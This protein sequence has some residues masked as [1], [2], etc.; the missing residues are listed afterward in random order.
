[1]RKSWVL[2][3]LLCIWAV[4]AAATTLVPMDL[5]DLT[6]ESSSVVYGKIVASRTEWDS[7]HTWIFTVYTVQP[8]EYLKGNL[9]TAFELS[10]LGGELDGLSMSVPAVPSFTVGQEA[11][12]FVWTS[13]QGQHQVTGFEQGAL[14][15]QRDPRTGVKTTE[16]AI[17]LGSASTVPSTLAAPSASRS[18]PQLFDQIRSSVAKARNRQ[19]KQ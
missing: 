13:P 15:V 6:V 7:R 2:L 3:A 19:P 9:G 5:D 17:R 1:M 16:R 14:T 18:L 10:E 4:G 8:I 11:V 12:L